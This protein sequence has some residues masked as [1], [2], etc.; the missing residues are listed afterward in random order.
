MNI[1]QMVWTWPHEEKSSRDRSGDLGGPARG[2][3]HWAIV[4]ESVIQKLLHPN[5]L[6]WTNFFSNPQKWK[7][8][9]NNYTDKWY[10]CNC[11]AF[12]LLRSLKLTISLRL[13]KHCIMNTYKF[14]TKSAYFSFSPHCSL[15]CFR[16][17]WAYIDR[18]V[19]THNHTKSFWFSISF[20]NIIPFVLFRV[21][22][23]NRANRIYIY[24]HMWHLLWRVGSCHRNIANKRE[25]CV[26]NIYYE[27][28]VHAILEP[29]EAPQS[30]I[31]RLETQEI[32]GLVQLQYKGWEPKV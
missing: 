13:L 8:N 24:I 5:M 4:W 10:I 12:K 19:C 17:I 29:W 23:R 18:C 31:C 27:E 28:L 2:F 16:H 3:L 32:G 25:K 9:V 30:A 14:P 6:K 11:I 22:Q 20:S 26:Y 7:S 21:L 1:G 15:R